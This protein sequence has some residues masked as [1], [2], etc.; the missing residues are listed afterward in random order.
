L[1]YRSI[2]VINDQEQARVSMVSQKNKI[3]Q[4]RGLRGTRRGG[5]IAQA[6]DC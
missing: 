2:L 6:A 4:C 5:G 3:A 1:F